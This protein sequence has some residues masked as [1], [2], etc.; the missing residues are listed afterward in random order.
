MKGHVIAK[1]KTI[2]FHFG[3]EYSATLLADVKTRSGGK[4]TQHNNVQ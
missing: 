3:K 4:L 1:M 2:F